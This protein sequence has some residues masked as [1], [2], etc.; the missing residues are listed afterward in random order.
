[1]SAM[2][3][4]NLCRSLTTL[5]Q[6]RGLSLPSPH[7]PVAHT[8]GASAWVFTMPHSATPDADPSAGAF[9]TPATA[10]PPR[11]PCLACA[12]LYIAAL[13]LAVGFGLGFGTTSAPLPRASGR[14]LENRTALLAA[15]L[16]PWAA[17]P[18]PS[19]ALL[20]ATSLLDGFSKDLAACSVATA[21][22]SWCPAVASVVASCSPARVRDSCSADFVAAARARCSA[23]AP[24]VATF[25]DVLD[26]CLGIVGLF[27]KCGRRDA[28][29]QLADIC[30]W[31]F[32]SGPDWAAG[33]NPCYQWFVGG[34]CRQRGEVTRVSSSV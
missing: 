27:G 14:G 8:L 21:A 30:E 12:V 19:N 15:W 34:Q 28:N 22:P 24:G 32:Y 26:A 2:N 31:G 16:A 13:A 20:M 25:E 29:C 3:V 6:H 4:S 11:P 7:A 33:Y 9:A 5:A 1:M 23:Q 17:G 18:V 10:A